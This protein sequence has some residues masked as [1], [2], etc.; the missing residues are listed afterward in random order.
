M[1]HDLLV[2]MDDPI[3]ENGLNVG[4]GRFTPT[5]IAATNYAVRSGMAEHRGFFDVAGDMAHA[6]EGD[7]AVKPRQK[8]GQIGDK[9]DE[10]R[11]EATCQTHCESGEDHG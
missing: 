3:M 4:K 9:R 1:N 6:K 8:K 2:E 5:P 7:W 11:I 10:A